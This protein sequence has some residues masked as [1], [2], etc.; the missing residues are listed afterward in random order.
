MISFQIFSVE[1]KKLMPKDLPIEIL[2]FGANFGEVMGV[3]NN[4]TPWKPIL[5][6]GIYFA[7]RILKHF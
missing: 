5:S 4:F 1:M 3:L 7:L 2:T 6:P